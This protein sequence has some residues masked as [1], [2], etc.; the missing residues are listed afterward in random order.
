M[1]N[2]IY[3]TNQASRLY[4]FNYQGDS[5]GEGEVVGDNENGPDLMVRATS[6]LS[7]E[8]YV[9]ITATFVDSVFEYYINKISIGTND[10]LSKIKITNLSLGGNFG[11]VG[12]SLN[13]NDNKYYVYFH[14]SDL[15]TVN[16]ETGAAEFVTRVDGAARGSGGMEFDSSGD[17]FLFLSTDGSENG[18][19]YKAET[20]YANATLIAS[21]PWFASAI[22]FDSGQLYA[23]R[24]RVPTVYILDKSNG[25]LIDSFNLTTEES[26]DIAGFQFHGFIFAPEVINS[27][28]TDDGQ[29]NTS[30]TETTGEVSN[31]EASGDQANA[32]N[33]EDIPSE[34]IT[35]SLIS[36]TKTTS[37]FNMTFNVIQQGVNDQ[38]SLP[39]SEVG[40]GVFTGSFKI[41]KS[42]G[43]YNK[44]GLAAII[45]N[46]PNPCTEINEK[47]IAFD[48]YDLYNRLD[49]DDMKDSLVSYGNI[50]DNLTPER[51]LQEYKT[52]PAG[53]R[54][55]SRQLTW[56]YDKDDP[57]FAFGN[58]KFFRVRFPTGNKGVSKDF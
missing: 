31:E 41:T 38:M 35:D 52:S 26:E 46:I 5:R 18:A 39:L 3:L 2:L 29:D 33:Q 58:P 47:R 25:D 28:S 20:P 8:N 55:E 22:N 45:I 11:P 42:D 21:K 23:V 4:K 19:I 15:Y 40:T 53:N 36:N 17:L 1:A 30:D 44:D 7:D 24:N 10:L 16:I 14:N 6:Y 49:L 57:K 54:F 56:P 50:V 9:A 32:T 34:D 43:V 48:K 27:T 12:L 37:A 51:L 13:P